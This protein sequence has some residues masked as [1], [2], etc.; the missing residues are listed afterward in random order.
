MPTTDTSLGVSRMTDQR[1][2]VTSGLPMARERLRWPDLA[3]IAVVMAVVFFRFSQTI[4]DP[5][6]WGHVKFGQIVWDSWR[7][8]L[9]DPFSYR[10][11]GHLWVNHEWLP[12][13][14]YYLIFAA[15][16]PV[17]LIGLKLGLSLLIHGLVYWH[18]CRQGL[19][20]LRAGILVLMMM[21]FFLISLMTARPLIVTYLL[22][23]LVVLLLDGMTRGRTRWLWGMPVLFALWANLHPGFL[24]GLAVVIIWSSV[25]LGARWLRGPLIARAHPSDRVI[26]LVAVTSVLAT[27]LNPY[28]PYLWKFL[29]ETATGP[30]PD[31][32][33]WQPLVVATRYGVAYL[34]LIGLAA[35]GVLYSRKQKDPGLMAVLVCTG[36]LPF[37]AYRHAPLSAMAIITIAGEHIGDALDRVAAA[38]KWGSR[39]PSRLRPWLGFTALG[40]AI[41]F[42]AGSATHFSCIRIEPWLGGS[43]PARAIRLIQQSGVRGNLAIDFDWG[44]Y[45]LY[46]LSP[47]VK[48]SVDGRRET[49]Y[50]PK[51][52][53]EN[54]D[55]MWGHG[56]WD[57]ILTRYDTQMV[58]VRT[59]YP[60]YNLMKL[61]PGWVLVYE[62]PLATLFA[63]EDLPVVDQ[64]RRTAAPS[65]PHDG[66]GLCFP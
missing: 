31:I 15:M 43:Q 30:R 52:Y 46:H 38:R 29:Y 61:K 22:F 66:A 58:L 23:L 26:I 19:I 33:E 4:A 41:A 64:L 65:L 16:G 3:V 8:A 54:L 47:A 48:V 5:D 49:G 42:L 2:G 13:V 39:E 44:L 63:R 35:S 60:A 12:E 9:P 56:Q 10:T 62:D 34:F 28:G 51:A 36:L 40:A 55:F 32:T 14:I 50:G 24:A 45:G 11:A 18:L 21:H 37:V 57:A 53:A 6:L 25:E 27:A 1:V 17:G 59:G 20:P 7:I